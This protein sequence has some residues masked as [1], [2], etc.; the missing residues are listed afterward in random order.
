[1]HQ[2]AR[3]AA[4]HKRYAGGL[5]GLDRSKSLPVGDSGCAQGLRAIGA[6]IDH[7]HGHGRVFPHPPAALTKLGKFRSKEGDINR[8]LG[9]GDYRDDELIKPLQPGQADSGS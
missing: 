9:V 3:A 4:V 5:H 1:M 7:A 8:L 2:A 6:V